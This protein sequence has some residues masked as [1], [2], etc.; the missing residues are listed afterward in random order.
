MKTT[1]IFLML[2]VAS[3][4][5]SAQQTQCV[6]NFEGE[7]FFGLNAP[8]GG[9]HGGD[10][11]GSGSLGVILRHNLKETPW[12]VGAFLRLDVARYKF[13][14]LEQG[15]RT[16]G[17]GVLGGYNFRQGKKVNPFVNLGVGLGCHDIVDSEVYPSS[18]ASM[19]AIPTVGVELFYHIRVNAYCELTR[20]GYNN[21]GVSL[22]VVI[23]GRPK[24]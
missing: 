16:L 6:Q 14:R 2:L 22:G 21:T 15:N 19:V 1:I 3:M 20:R 17:L 13:D 11:V 8:V 4:T 12:D 5:A 23:G 7:F 24:R 10:A 9:Y 18:G